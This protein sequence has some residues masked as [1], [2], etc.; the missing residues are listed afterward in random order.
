MLHTL[1]VAR[2]MRESGIGEERVNKLAGDTIQ[3]NAELATATRMIHR[4]Y[5]EPLLKAM[6]PA[7]TRKYYYD[8]CLAQG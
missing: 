7:R 4:I 3:D 6:S 8:A 2:E 5:T 1:K